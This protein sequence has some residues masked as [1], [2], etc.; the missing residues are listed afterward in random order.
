MPLSFDIDNP[1]F[2][3][4]EDASVIRAQEARMRLSTAPGTL[5]E[6]PQYGFLLSSL[7][8]QGLT[9][10]ALARTPDAV[11]AQ[12]QLDPANATVVVVPTV[13]R[14]ANGDYGLDL[15]ITITP[16]G[17]EQPITFTLPAGG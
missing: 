12:L 17:E 1:F 10:E 4:T 15:G 3:L 13:T 11:R 5:V 6:D 9:A 7:V 2:E 8:E 14:D 16:S